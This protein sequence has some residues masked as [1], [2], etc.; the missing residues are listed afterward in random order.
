MVTNNDC[1]GIGKDAIVRLRE[2]ILATG[3]KEWS[4]HPVSTISPIIFNSGEKPV[5]PPAKPEFG[6]AMP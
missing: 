1:I 4:D 3:R 6:C 5:I 2:S